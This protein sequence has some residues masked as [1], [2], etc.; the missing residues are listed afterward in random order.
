[1]KQ[2]NVG[3][4]GFGMAGRLFHGPTINS[5]EGLKLYKVRETKAP[6]ISIIRERY[7][8]TVVV[9]DTD[10]ILNDPSIDLVVVATPNVIHY[11]VATQA[12]NANKHVI[13]DKPF[14]VTSAEAS[15]LITLAKT[16]NK[17]LTAYQNRRW[18]SDFLTV[19]KVIASNLLGDL[20]EYEAHYDRFRNTI[21]PDTWKEDGVLGTGLVYDLGSH[22]IDQAQVLFGLPLTVTAF[23]RTQ[24]QHARIVDNFEIILD[25]GKIKV[26][27]KGGMLIKEPLPHFILLGNNGSFIKY[28]MDVQE[29]ALIAG[30]VPNKTINWGEEPESLW[31]TINTEM[32]GVEFRGKIKSEKGDY[33]GY[34]QNVYKAIIGEEELA[35]KPE[36]ARNTI[37]IIELAMQS[38]EEKRTIPY[39]D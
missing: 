31:G 33:V 19:K 39:A 22:L 20:I 38:N 4:I 12:I 29:E 8:D 23:L 5:T 17:L 35:V 9:N 16:K 1:M 24:R 34:Y 28:G 11:N 10:E 18:D 14:T 21:R 2:I 25:Y 13:V 7:P 26:T 36:Q 37:R 3:L 15:V 30:H 32:N 6:N 27:L